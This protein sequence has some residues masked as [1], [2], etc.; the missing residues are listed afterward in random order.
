LIGKQGAEEWI[1]R[2]SNEASEAHERRLLRRCRKRLQCVWTPGE[3]ALSVEGVQQRLRAQREALSLAERQGGLEEQQNALAQQRARQVARLAVLPQGL[4]Q[5]QSLAPSHFRAY[6]SACSAD[7][8]SLCSGSS[9]QADRQTGRHT[10][11]H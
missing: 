11:T 5:V 4:L 10:Q 7:V 9:R 3:A 1:E 6:K 2:R 8:P